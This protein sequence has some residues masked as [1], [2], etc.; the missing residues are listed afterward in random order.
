MDNKRILQGLKERF[1]LILAFTTEEEKHDDLNYLGGFIS[2]LVFGELISPEV[3]S[4]Y[5]RKL[6]SEGLEID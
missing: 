2:G 3:Y 6:E 5:L 1:E 4:K